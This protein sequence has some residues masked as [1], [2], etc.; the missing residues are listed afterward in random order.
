[1]FKRQTLIV[2]LTLVA[3]TVMPFSALAQTQIK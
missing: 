1:M 2:W 3:I